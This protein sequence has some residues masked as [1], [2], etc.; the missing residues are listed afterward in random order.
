MRIVIAKVQSHGNYD[1]LEAALAARYP[2]AQIDVLPPHDFVNAIKLRAQGVDRS[3]AYYKQDIAPNLAILPDITGN[4]SPYAELFAG[5]RVD[6]ALSSFIN[7][8]GNVMAFCAGAVYLT[9]TSHFHFAGDNHNTKCPTLKTM[10]AGESKGPILQADPQTL[11]VG[12]NAYAETIPVT[13]EGTE[14]TINVP[15]HAG[16][17]FLLPASDTQNAARQES[18]VLM[19]YNLEALSLR[20]ENGIQQGIAALAVNFNAPASGKLVLSGPVPHAGNGDGDS[21]LAFTHLLTPFVMQQQQLRARVL[22]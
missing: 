9:R 3:R 2:G 20:T 4:K 18:V 14:G 10:F 12:K 16:P 19:R 22:G 6:H 8:G 17:M 5:Q 11:P 13:L 7:M 15:Y 1:R 21:E